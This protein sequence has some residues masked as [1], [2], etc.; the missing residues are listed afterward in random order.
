MLRKLL[1]GFFLF[2]GLAETSAQQDPQYSQYMFNPLV[3]N[4]AYAGSRDMFSAVALYRNQWISLPG[5]PVTQTVSINTPLKDP[6]LGVGLHVINDK[7]GPKQTTGILTSYAYR[8]AMAKGKLALGLRAGIY[9]YRLNYDMIEFKDPDVFYGNKTHYTPTVDFGTYYY[10]KKFY[11]GACVSHIDQSKYGTNPTSN[12]DSR[13]VSHLVATAGYAMVFSKH[14]TFRPSM[15]LKAVK[16]APP[17]FDLNAAILLNENLWIG[18][19][20]RSKNEGLVMFEYAISKNLRA[21]Y[22]FDIQF[23]K[24]RT[25]TQGSHEIFLGFDFELFKAKTLSPRYF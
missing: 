9:S 7:I 1:L 16:N 25:A 4:P 22:S 2:A 20:A 19:G 14:I 12:T 6:K 8:I 21:G 18:M 3:L 15:V 11:A 13:L 10:T 24:V 5:A 23:S 17:T